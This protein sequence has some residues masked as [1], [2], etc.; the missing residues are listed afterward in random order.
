MGKGSGRRPSQISEEQYQ[1]NYDRIFRT[2]KK[3]GGRA[4]GRSFGTCYCGHQEEPQ[5]PPCSAITEINDCRVRCQVRE[6]HTVHS[7]ELG[8]VGHI[9]TDVLMGTYVVDRET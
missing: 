1:E 5:A 6:E 7:A 9:W 3:C 8:E 4:T 2:P